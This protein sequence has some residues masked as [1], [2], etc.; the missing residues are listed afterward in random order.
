MA[1]TVKMQSRRAGFDP[2]VR[3]IPWGRNWQPTP[4]F[5]PEE[6]HGQR[7]LA[8]CS[9]WSLKELDMTEQL[10]RTSSDVGRLPAQTTLEPLHSTR[11]L[12]SCCRL[13]SLA[14]WSCSVLAPPTELLLVQVTSP[15][16]TVPRALCH[17]RSLPGPCWQ[18]HGHQASKATETVAAG[19]SFCPLRSSKEHSV[20]L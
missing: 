10:T 11:E 13:C 9:P 2:W 6:S 12:S 19:F 16:L 3:K 17:G 20:F 14:L 18:C 1:Q 5:L 8:G 7:S 4:I 15:P